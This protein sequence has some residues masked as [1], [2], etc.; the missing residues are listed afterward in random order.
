METKNEI[1]QQQQ[2]QPTKKKRPTYQSMIAAAIGDL[3]ENQGSS[4][5][6]IQQYIETNYGPVHAPAFRAALHK[7]VT[8]GRLSQIGQSFK[9]GS[10]RRQKRQKK[11]KNGSGKNKKKTKSNSK[12]NT[13]T[14]T[15]KQK[16]KKKKKVN[17]ANPPLLQKQPRP[18]VFAKEV[19]TCKRHLITQS[20][21]SSSCAVNTDA[22]TM[23][24]EIVTTL[25]TKG[26]GD[27]ELSPIVTHLATFA[28]SHG[29]VA[30]AFFKRF[31]DEDIK[32]LSD[33]LSTPEKRESLQRFFETNATV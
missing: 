3:K 8:D 22:G 18:S 20:S 31:C 29:C 6:K 33:H 5:I 24:N 2:E 4:R 23:L 16:S 12:N 19:K 21:S 10:K 30:M 13:K 7:G 17:E 15:K 26:A 9:I 32:V 14:S 25:K 28:N 27:A 1:A 11:N